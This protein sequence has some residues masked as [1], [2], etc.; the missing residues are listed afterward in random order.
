ME[1]SFTNP[2]PTATKRIL[3]EYTSLLESSEF[4]NINIDFEDDIN[5]YIWTVSID[6]NFYNIS[7]NFRRDFDVY[8][9]R[10]GRERIMVFEIRFNGNY[11]SEPPFIRIVR[12]RIALRSGHVTVGGSICAEGLTKDGWNQQRSVENVLVEVFVNL[13]AGDASLDIAGSKWDYML[14]EAQ[15]AFRRSAAT[16]GWRS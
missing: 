5:I 13:A 3:Q 2:T 8:M 4:K 14:C 1:A 16:H 6:L 10:Y 11:P 9:A 7:D 15:E 12:P